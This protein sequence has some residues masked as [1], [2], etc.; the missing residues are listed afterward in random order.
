[1]KRLQVTLMA[2][3]DKHVYFN[4]SSKKLASCVVVFLLK[5]CLAMGLACF[6]TQFFLCGAFAFLAWDTQAAFAAQ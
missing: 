5:Q 6:L 3:G 4:N 2:G 1:M